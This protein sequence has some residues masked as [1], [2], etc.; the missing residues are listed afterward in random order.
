MYGSHSQ[1]LKSVKVSPFETLELVRSVQHSHGSTSKGRGTIKTKITYLIWV[2]V[3]ADDGTLL[4]IVD[5]AR[6]TR[7]TTA[8][9]IYKLVLKHGVA[10]YEKLCDMAADLARDERFQRGG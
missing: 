10:G 3:Y 5:V 4:D 1:T 8:N 9:K 2:R 7:Q 6:E